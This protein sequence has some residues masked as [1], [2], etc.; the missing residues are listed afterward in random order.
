ER[1]GEVCAV[2]RARTVTV[3]VALL[4]DEQA[5]GP[6]PTTVSAYVVVA[7]GVATGVQLDGSSSPVAGAHEHE[8][9]PEPP[10]GVDSP[11]QMVFEPEAT[12]VGGEHTS[13]PGSEN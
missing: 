3:A 6:L 5:A 4:V 13:H 9:P 7:A 1:S 12:A 8:T 2:G 11:G 10:S